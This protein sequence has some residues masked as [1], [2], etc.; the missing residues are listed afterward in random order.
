MGE[1][2]R[3]LRREPKAGKAPR[4][5]FSRGRMECEEILLSMHEGNVDR[6]LIDAARAGGLLDVRFLLSHGAD[7]V[8]VHIKFDVLGRQ[9]RSSALY[10]AAWNGNLEVARALVDAAGAP[11]HG[12]LFGIA[13]DMA[14]MESNTA[15]ALLLLDRGASLNAEHCEVTQWCALRGNLVR[16]LLARGAEIGA[17][18]L[19]IAREQG[20]DDM[21][22]LLLEH[23]V[24]ED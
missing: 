22:R 7:S 9:S 15:V 24:E 11:G 12:E 2:S 6:T 16:N 8:Y 13:L 18:E 4:P 1:G 20:N 3:R 19:R 21:V 5:V 14:A 23:G 17:A 10:G